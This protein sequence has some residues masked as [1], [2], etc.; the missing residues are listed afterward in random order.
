MVKRAFGALAA[1]AVLAAGGAVPAGA[2][3]TCRQILIATTRT[4]SPIT[5]TPLDAIAFP[6][7]LVPAAATVTR[8]ITVCPPGATLPLVTPPAPFVIGVPVVGTPEFE[9]PIVGPVVLPVIQPGTGTAPPA[10]PVA[11]PPAVPLVTGAVP[12]DTVAG[13]AAQAA[14]FDRTVVTVTGTAAAVQQTADAQGSPLTVFRLEAG[15]RSVGVVAW[16]RSTVREGERVRVSGPFYL[17]TPF[18][19]PSG[20]PWHDVIEADLLER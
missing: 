10:P 5:V 13:L 14:R 15:G 9:V 3:G 19:G 4:S 18:A 1:A 11:A 7:P 20:A 2:Q 6:V 17:S 16:G 12:N 8:Q